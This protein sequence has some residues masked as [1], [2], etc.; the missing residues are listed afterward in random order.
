MLQ[1]LLRNCAVPT[2]LAP[3]F[4]LNPALTSRATI[5]SPFGLRFRAGI[6]AFVPP[7]IVGMSFVTAVFSVVKQKPQLRALA[8]GRG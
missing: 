4:S 8:L 6:D 2:A 3:N 1:S 5:V 7:Q